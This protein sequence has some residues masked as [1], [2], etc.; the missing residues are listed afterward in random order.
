MSPNKSDKALLR[1]HG[2][3]DEP[4]DIVDEQ[5]NHRGSHSGVWGFTTGQRRGL[6]VPSQEPLYVLRTDSQA[7]TVVVGPRA[8]LAVETISAR[9]RLYVRVNRA[10]VKWRYRSPAVPTAVEETERG[11]RLH[12]DAPAHGVS[13]GQA[14]VLYDEGVVVGVG[15]L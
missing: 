15:V 10:E 11:F 3:D 1:R 5:G 7:N 12:L 9:G 13:P 6:G 4:G 2:V 8:S 14:A